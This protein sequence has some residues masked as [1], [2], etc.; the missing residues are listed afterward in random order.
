VTRCL[1]DGKRVFL[2]QRVRGSVRAVRAIRN[3]QVF[4]TD[5]KVVAD[6]HTLD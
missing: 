5:T 3:T 2:Y 1:G 6:G 4:Q